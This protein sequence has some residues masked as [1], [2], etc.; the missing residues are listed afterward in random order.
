[1][2]AEPQYT[3]ET[4]PSTTL[5]SDLWPTMTLSQLSRQ[6]ELVIDKISRMHILIGAS[7]T[8]ALQNLYGALQVALRDLNALIDN[9][10][11]TQK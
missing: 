3:P 7:A 2:P 8:P 9:R 5:R 6:Q 1:M 4:D 10:S 11:A